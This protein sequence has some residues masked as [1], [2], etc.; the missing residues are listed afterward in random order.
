M[1]N[2]V[3]GILQSR[4]MQT[5]RAYFRQEQAFK[6]CLPFFCDIKEVKNVAKRNI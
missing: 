2:K 4:G 5:R 6:M 3:E 1:L